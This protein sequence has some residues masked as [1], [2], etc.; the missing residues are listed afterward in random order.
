MNCNSWYIIFYM[1]IHFIFILIKYYHNVYFSVQFVSRIIIK[2]DID[3]FPKFKLSGGPGS[4]LIGLNQSAKHFKG[5]CIFETG[6]INYRQIEENNDKKYFLYFPNPYFFCKHIPQ[7]Y[8]RNPEKL[9]NVFFGP[10]LVPMG[11]Y[12]FPKKRYCAERHFSQT[13]DMSGSVIVHSDRVRDHLV[14]KSGTENKKHK[15]GIMRA[16]SN[17]IPNG[18]KSFKN[19]K[20][21]I[22]LYEKYSDLDRR[23]DGELLFN[24][25][26]NK[27]FS[28]KRLS[29]KGTVDGAPGYNY[30][31]LKKIANNTRFIIYFSFWDTGAISLK[32]IQNFGVYSFAVQKDLVHNQTGTFIPELDGNIKKAA[33]II[34]E[35][36][37]NIYKNEIDAEKVAKLNQY[38]NSCQRSLEDLCNIAIKKLSK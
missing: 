18:I 14:N 9:N 16:C 19:R 24:L 4:L 20:F 32:E 6:P 26:M 38:Q 34:S 25:L 36:I 29:Y 12:S 35:S 31:S 7:M 5:K 22:L 13:L 27:S 37:R 10:F 3:P 30:S 2:I 1:I 28:I 17:V 8:K 21:D 11:W 33:E 15:I 23:K